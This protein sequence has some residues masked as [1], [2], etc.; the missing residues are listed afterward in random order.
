MNKPPQLYHDTPRGDLRKLWGT[1]TRQLR[2]R[3]GPDNAGNP[4][5][6]ADIV[7]A[8]IY[9]KEHTGAMW[10]LSIGMAEMA[11]PV[12]LEQTIHA[13]AD[14][15]KAVK[16]NPPFTSEVWQTDTG[17]IQH[18]GT[19]HPVNPPSTRYGLIRAHMPDEIIRWDNRN[20]VRYQ[21]VRRVVA[22][23]A[24][25]DLYAEVEV[26]TPATTGGNNEAGS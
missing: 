13:P 17:F 26:P 1:D 9:D 20:V 24:D 15:Y 2:I 23:H 3:F 25:R 8:Q 19:P 4:W 7:E 14:E 16:Q 11:P 5:D 12:Y 6:G 21:E 22:S 18:I 10:R